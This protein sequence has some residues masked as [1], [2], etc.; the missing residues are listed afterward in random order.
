MR[1]LLLISL[2]S[3]GCSS[4]PVDDSV[5][6]YDVELRGALETMDDYRAY[7]ARIDGAMDRAVDEARADR[8]TQCEVMTYGAKPCGGHSAARVFSTA[9]G[10]PEG[11]QQLGALF[12]RVQ[13][14]MNTRFELVSD[15]M[16]EPVPSPAL[17]D[18]RC[19]AADP[20]D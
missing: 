19:V 10:D 15:C 20:Q 6:D 13:N 8:A 11:L 5:T 1:F 16:M 12:T 9:D 4:T 2:L 14:D 3:L 17:Q 18:G 7:L